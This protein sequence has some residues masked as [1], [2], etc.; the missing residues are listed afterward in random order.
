MGLSF[1]NE[2]FIKFLKDCNGPLSV[3]RFPDADDE[4]DVDVVDCSDSETASALRH[5]RHHNTNKSIYKQRQTHNDCSGSNNS[6]NHNS[7]SSSSR[8]RAS[9]Q[10]P[11]NTEEERLTPE[12]AKS[13]P[14][15]VGS[16]NCDDL[17][18]V[19]CHLETKELWDKFHELGTEMI[20]TKTGR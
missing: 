6:N 15:I 1:P 14:K 2:E 20:I 10:S 17:L 19:Q 5:T 11:S 8:G 3:E 13:S 16:C 7:S 4:V 9:S 12:P 18:P